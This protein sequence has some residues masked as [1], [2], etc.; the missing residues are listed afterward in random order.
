MS[1]GIA[2]HIVDY[3]L[4]RGIGIGEKWI[5]VVSD[6]SWAVLVCPGLMKEG[7]VRAGRRLLPEAGV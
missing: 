6:R 3:C 2:H 1:A 7:S 4:N 5:S